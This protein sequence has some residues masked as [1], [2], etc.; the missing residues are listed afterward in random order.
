MSD[1]IGLSLQ[2]CVGLG[3]VTGP[4]PNKDEGKR[5]AHVTLSSLRSW[6]PSR[7]A[8]SQLTALQ[9]R[10]APRLHPGK[11]CARYEMM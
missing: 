11:V 4:C 9:R 2:K 7:P 5:S 8:F 1:W 3:L 6:R 10:W